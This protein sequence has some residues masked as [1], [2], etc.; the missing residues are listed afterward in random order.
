MKTNHK[1][2]ALLKEHGITWPLPGPVSEMDPPKLEFVEDCLLLANEH[3]RNKHI[4]TA[5]FSDKTGFE[6]F[7]NHVHLTFAGSRQSLLSCL[8]Y[9][10]ALE[11][12]LKEQQCCCRVIVGISEGDCAVRFHQIRPGEA[13]VTENLES[14][15]RE[16]IMIFD[17]PS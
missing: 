12:A 9:A 16:A 11:I 14:Y 17:V 8:K 5:D 6:C 13:W 3:Q 15:E 1:M 10:V 7:I 2:D 4:R